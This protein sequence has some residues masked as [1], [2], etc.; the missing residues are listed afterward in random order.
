MFPELAGNATVTAPSPTGLIQ[1]IL[2]GAAM[3][4]TRQ[5]PA[6]L[7]MPGFADRLSDDE[8]AALATFVRSGWGNKAAAVSAGD[9]AAARNDGAAE[10]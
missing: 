4:S 6:Q 7:T 2:H 8:V 9:V 10:K 3:P 5:R 1:T